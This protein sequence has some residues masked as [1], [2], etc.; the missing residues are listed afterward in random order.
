[1]EHQ[2]DISRSL[3]ESV[4]NDY[5]TDSLIDLSQSL[6]NDGF[7]VLKN[8]EILNQIPVIKILAAGVKGVSSFQDRR[9]TSKILR[10]M[11]ETAKADDED[12]I[13]YRAKLD[14]DPEEVRKAGEEILDILDKITSAEKAIMIGQVFRAYMH[15]DEITTNLLVYLCEIIERAYL[16]DL[17]DLGNNTVTNDV[18]LENVGIKKP[19]RIE[20]INNVVQR[21][22]DQA[23][24]KA[25]S[26]SGVVREAPATVQL[27]RLESIK[28]APSHIQ[29]KQSGL[30]QE[31]YTLQRI[32]QTYKR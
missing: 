6:L 12:K 18:N 16:K 17:T 15:E 9:Y 22:V 27:A 29:I 23:V 13:K 21:A 19:V 32:L 25:T 11:S 10:F 30:T 2:E 20:D 3:M 14:A 8:S 4:A 28:L 31:G 1:M 7:E 5:T 24:A 26:Q